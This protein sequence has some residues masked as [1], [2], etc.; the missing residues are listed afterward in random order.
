MNDRVALRG[1]AVFVDRDGTLN[2]DY[3]YITSSSQLVL[4]HG[5][6]EAIARLNRIGV[7]VIMVTNQSA[8]GRGL[9]TLQD[10]ES[11]HNRLATM[12]R[13]S[14]AHMDAIFYCPHHPRD[15]CDCR[16]PKTGLIDQAV[17]RFSLEVGQ[18]FFVGDK[19][20]DLAAAQHAGVPGV[21]VLTSPYGA[22]ALKA[23]DEGELRIE[24]VADTFVQAVNWIEQQ[25]VKC[26]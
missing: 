9:M 1:T 3:G 12:I 8:I 20:S 14:G 26:R 10:L 2:H 11:I 13:P 6:P 15:G 5:V 4:F 23:R 25:L 17:K 16:K 22:E 18:C 21:L 19:H 24:H 7:K